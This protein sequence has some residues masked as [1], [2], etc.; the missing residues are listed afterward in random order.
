D[1]CSHYP[2]PPAFPLAE[3]PFDEHRV[4]LRTE[5]NGMEI[6]S[7]SS[8][9]RRARPLPQ[10]LFVEDMQPTVVRPA[11]SEACQIKLRYVMVLPGL[12]RHDAHLLL[13]IIFELALISIPGS[14][15]PVPPFLNTDCSAAFLLLLQGLRFYLPE[16]FRLQTRVRFCSAAPFHLQHQP[17]LS[18]PPHS[19]QKG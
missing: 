11:L 7:M 18:Q 6:P 10:L 15:I 8:A 12:I 4:V 17:F 3:S 1:N 2:A 5:I 14:Y 9:L 16:F 13:S 19:E